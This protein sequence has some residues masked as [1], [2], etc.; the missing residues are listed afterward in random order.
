MKRFLVNLVGTALLASGC[1][2][3]KTLTRDSA[4]EIMGKVATQ[5]SLTQLT[6]T[7]ERAK[8]LQSLGPQINTLGV[9]NGKPCLPDRGDMRIFTGQFVLCQGMIPPEITGM[10]HGVLLSLNKPFT[11]KIVEMT[12]IADAPDAKNEKLVEYTW[13]YDFSAYA[14]ELQDIFSIPPRPGRALFR[15]YDDGWRFVEY[16]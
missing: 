7:V 1:S 12:G 3:G 16:K 14:K 4:K 10:Q 9:I 6:I 5:E 8:K 11:W 15:L 13:Q 2:S